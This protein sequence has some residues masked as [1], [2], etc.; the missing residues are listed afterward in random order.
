LQADSAGKSG[1]GTCAEC[2][3]KAAPE[4]AEIGKSGLIGDDRYQVTAPPGLTVGQR[5]PKLFQ[6]LGQKIGA[7][8]RV[9]RRKSPLQLLGKNAKVVCNPR[10]SAAQRAVC[11]I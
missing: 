1:T 8:C 10:T 5:A 11:Q 2:L 6:P 7:R 9:D 3:A 4:I